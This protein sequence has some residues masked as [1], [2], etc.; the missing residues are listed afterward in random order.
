MATPAQTQVTLD[1]SQFISSVDQIGVSIDAMNKQL[2]SA[3]TAFNTF[4]ASSA[5]MEASLKSIET[6]TA[7]LNAT[8][9][10]IAI[11]TRATAVSIDQLVSS[12]SKAPTTAKA[13]AQS[14]NQV[15]S[16]AQAAGQQ[17]ARGAQQF[18]FAWDGIARLLAV[19]VIRRI[20]LDIAGAIAASVAASAEYQEQVG[21]IIALNQSLGTSADQLS[22]RF[23]N[24]SLAYGR[25]LKDVADIGRIASTAGGAQTAD[26]ID[27]ITNSSIRLAEVTGSTGPAA[28]TAITA[29]TR[30]FH[31]TA[32]E[33][34]NV[35]NQLIYLTQS[36]IGVEAISGSIGRVASQAQRLG[37]SFSE[38]G[39]LMQAIKE[40]GVSDAEVMTQIA[41]ALNSI[42]RPSRSLQQL[43]A[44]QGIF[45]PQQAIQAQRL[46]GTLQQ[47]ARDTS[48]E[49]IQASRALQ[50]RRAGGVLSVADTFA[51]RSQNN[52]LD[53]ISQLQQGADAALRIVDATGRW[54]DELEKIKTIF[55][56]EIA[57]AIINSILGIF[58]STGGLAKAFTDAGRTIALLVEPIVRVIHGFAIFGSLLERIAE[59]LHIISSS[60]RLNAEA[61]RAFSAAAQQ[62][63]ER[64]NT[65]VA[66]QRQLARTTLQEGTQAIANTFTPINQA[67]GRQAELQRERVHQ[68]GE[69]IEAS[70][71][72][73]FGAF[74]AQIES[75][76]TAS[77]QAES[78]ITES[79]K[80]VSDLSDKTDKDA[81]SHRLKSAG[82]VSQTSQF[83]SDQQAQNAFKLLEA[84]NGASDNQLNL[85][86]E[87]RRRLQEDI[88]QLQARGDADSI[89]A[90]RRKF[91]ELRQLNEQENDIRAGRARRNAE[92]DARA[93]GQDQTFNPFNR[94]REAGARR[95]DA[96]ER[97]FEEA[98]R[99]RLTAQQQALEKI[100][101]ALR[102][103]FRL[104]QD[105][106]RDVGRLPQRLLGTDGLPRETFRGTD[107][108]QRAQDLI[109]GT[110]DQQ[111]ER[112]KSLP[113][114]IERSIQDALR[115]G[116]ITNE[117]ADQARRRAPSPQEIASLVSQLEQQKIATRAL[118]ENSE[119][120]RV[121]EANQARAISILQR[122]ADNTSLAI[123]RVAETRQQQRSLLSD[124][125]AQVNQ[126][127]QQIP[128]RA[129]ML[130][131][132]TGEAGVR[133]RDRFV[134]ALE[135]FDRRNATAVRTGDQSDI[136]RA[137]AQAA[138]VI[139]HAENLQRIR[140]VNGPQPGIE[141]LR[142]VVERLEATLRERAIRENALGTEQQIAARTNETIRNNVAP[143]G[144][145]ATTVQQSITAF[146][147]LATAM[148]P[149]GPFPSALG[150]LAGI[151]A[152]ASGNIAA[153]TASLQV[154]AAAP[155]GFASG[156]L[157]GNAFSNFGPDNT[158]IHARRGEF[159]V[160]PDSTRKFYSTLVAINRGDRPRGGGY[161]H[162]GTVTNSIGNM[163]FHVSGADHP[164]QTARAVMK[165]IR[166]EQRRGNV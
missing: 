80:R 11:S 53:N 134:Q 141:A 1:A 161:A 6:S 160:N 46:S 137:R 28:A 45:N 58:E 57:P 81:F 83:T 51:Q 4:A 24:L 105:G 12:L 158:M 124:A 34:Q 95:L 121:N 138:L 41:A 13:A 78:R 112:V 7:P 90:A 125:Q 151:I 152:A 10:Q 60:A 18:T 74:G 30:A 148:S 126:I 3:G 82:D 72:S 98:N 140:G 153:A 106:Q 25:S 163:N 159:V 62:G 86:R 156:G 16:A 122:I 132:G 99:R 100:N 89:A 102:E 154:P 116:A 101:R 108:G 49:N 139:Q 128:T 20:F 162:G 85:I 36:G 68:L 76:E 136:D 56:S 44:G 70:S 130:G 103:Q 155:E 119:A 123:T 21:R 118:F 104:M 15:G 67:L 117:Q 47:L 35:S 37:V 29:I 5:K 133:A 96:A 109:S 9:Q 77:R 150:E 40:T 127:R 79:L 64:L 115:S 145:P 92:F 63:N 91:E 94:E 42:E 165:I 164:E 54:N 71:K 22:A 131:E 149:T 93:T 97:A 39:L 142:G 43:W 14:L 135:E 84:Q 113:E 143:G 144:V 27:A 17:G 111:I 129:G 38:L 75:L 65:W 8:L 166:R 88:A 73:I 61:M 107:G 50:S 31:M 87:R 69:E 52:P 110:I 23:T 48:E 147:N 66:L 26:Q 157:I 146:E 19:T 32:E 59:T 2:A 55:Q 33:S 120:R 114:T